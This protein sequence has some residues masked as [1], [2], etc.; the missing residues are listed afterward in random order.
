MYVAVITAAEPGSR[1]RC[2]N[3]LYPHHRDSSSLLLIEE[4]FDHLAYHLAIPLPTFG[5][6]APE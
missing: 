5:R 1:M 2:P 6:F 4:T 3:P